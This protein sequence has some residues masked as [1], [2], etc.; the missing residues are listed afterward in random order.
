MARLSQKQQVL[1]IGLGRFGAAL[2]RELERLGHEVLA[3]DKDAARVEELGPQ[4]THAVCADATQLPVLEQ[5][6]AKDFDAAIVAMGTDERSSILITVLLKK[7][8]VKSVIAR[9]F[10]DL[11]AEILEKVGATRV[12]DPDRE[13]GA[14]VAHSFGGGELVL[15][16]YQ[17]APG[18]GLE[19]VSARKFQG[20]T[21][22]ELDLR[23]RFGLTPVFLHR[24]QAVIV[25]P[26]DSER[27]QADDEL[28]LAGLDERLEKLRLD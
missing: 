27:L 13:T 26:D 12:V 9:A 18:F 15:D 5:L 21:L 25:S 7:C 10:D 11:H 6:G 1:V 24:G 17:V 14:R 28:G 2:A 3:V 22:G 19:R 16:Y 20:K 23:G 4:V 8:G